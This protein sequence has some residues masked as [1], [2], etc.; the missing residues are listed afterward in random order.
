MSNRYGRYVQ[1]TQLTGV[2]HLFGRDLRRDGWFIGEE[3]VLQGRRWP[4]LR[5]DKRPTE[6]SPDPAVIWALRNRRRG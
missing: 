1:E 2:D 6:T 5:S 3:S 4:S